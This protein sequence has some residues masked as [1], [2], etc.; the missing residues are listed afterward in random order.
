MVID[1]LWAG[2]SVLGV[3]ICHLNG[4]VRGGVRGVWDSRDRGQSFCQSGC[5]RWWWGKKT[6]VRD[7]KTQRL[8]SFSLHHLLQFC[9]GPLLIVVTHG[10]KLWE[11]PPYSHEYLN[12][13]LSPS[14]LSISGVSATMGSR[15]LP[16]QAGAH[17]RLCPDM[18][19]RNH[20]NRHSGPL[21]SALKSHLMLVPEWVSL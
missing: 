21:V 7:L 11:Q 9:R 17:G 4:N 18:Y 13:L 12:N 3:H 19:V 15:M 1:S 5:T 6:N 8:I 20:G 2:D 10:P 14:F 16:A